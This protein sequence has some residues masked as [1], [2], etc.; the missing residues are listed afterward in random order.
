MPELALGLVVC[1]ALYFAAIYGFA[2]AGWWRIT[3]VSWRRVSLDPGPK[4]PSS[5]EAVSRY[6][7]DIAI[8]YAIF[9]TLLA[10]AGFT[11]WQRL[12][13]AALGALF[14][15]SLWIANS[16]GDVR[17]E[18]ASS[19]RQM[20]NSAGYWGLSVVGWLGYL[21]MLCFGSALIVEIFQRVLV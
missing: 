18:N 3:W 16:Q 2:W 4:S 6:G 1:A 12:G 17:L 7:V 13:I 15:G 9:F 19:A 21:G 14:Y 10:L 8:I 20:A 11:V 5:S